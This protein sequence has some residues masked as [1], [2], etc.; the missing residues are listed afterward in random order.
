MYFIRTFIILFLLLQLSS[1]LY[2]QNFF[3]YGVVVDGD[4]QQPLANASIFINNSTSGTVTNTAGEFKLGPFVPGEYEVVASFVGYHKILY[5]ANLHAASLKISFQMGRKEQQM[6]ELLI[7][8]SETRMRYLEIFKR[9]LLG[10]TAAAERAKIK[11]L[12]DVQFT[13]GQNS[14]EII[15]YCDTTLVVDNPEL[16]YVINF[17]L[18]DFYFNRTTGESRFFGYTRFVDKD[19]EGETKRKWARR[20]K[21]TY[22]GSSMHFFRSLVNKN[23]KQEGFTMQNVYR[24]ELK[25]EPGETI[26]LRSNGTSSIEVAVP[27]TE[28]SVLHLYKDSG[29]RIYQLKVAHWLRVLYN[30]NTNL[31]NEVT[32][33]RI[34]TGQMR[35][36]TV[37]GIR[38]VKPPVPI[39]IDYRGR[40]LTAMSFY[41]DGIWMYERLANMLPED[42]VPE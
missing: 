11:N 4:T 18:V 37:S 20:R 17:D 40:L 13:T 39:L 29:Y 22:D 5:V 25:R 35:D 12:K 28:D 6:R 15:A 2:A 42:Y 1:S 23:L 26:T 3:I 33:N 34:I 27:V 19:T 14:S 24:K 8:P 32:R 9:T 36:G 31:K 10:Q 30:K 38:P 41:H 7:L 21:Q 16:G